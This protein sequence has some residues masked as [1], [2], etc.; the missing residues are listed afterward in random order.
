MDPIKF[1]KIRQFRE[2]VR[3]VRAKAQFRGLDESGV[4]I[5]DRDAKMPTIEY[6][7]T[8]KMHGTNASVRL[9][10]DGEVFA[11]SRNQVLTPDIKD[12]HG[13]RAYSLDSIGRDFWIETLSE[14]K[15]EA[16]INDEVVVYGE[17]IGKGVAKGAAVC[18]IPDNSFVVFAVR[19][20]S[21]E[22][23]VWLDDSFISKFSF[24]EYR[25]YNSTMFKRYSMTIDF[26]DLEPAR[27]EL[28]RL[29]DIVEKCCPVA[30]ELG[31]EGTGEGIVWRPSYS[32]EFHKG[33]FW[34]K[35]KGEKHKD[36]GKG[37]KNK[38]EIS[39]EKLKNIDDFVSYCLTDV[40]LEKGIAYLVEMD[41][42]L[43]RKSTGQFLKWIG[44]DVLDEE[45]D[46]LEESGLERKDITGKLNQ[47]ARNWYFKYINKMV[48][49]NE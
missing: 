29:T 37:K 3:E 40:R 45:S 15:Q 13:W 21:G 49:E 17:Y 41:I 9:T 7:G 22:D 26:N 23:T 16:E 27:E 18:L 20:G 31:V 24:P 30:K 5:M 6:V 34:F 2:V 33:R 1:P 28:Q 25:I 8:V 19:I 14:I 12:N 39:P 43:S 46:T 4:P 38:V 32:S 47:A 42:P 11:Q 36:S 10:Q 48:F 44:N 35:T